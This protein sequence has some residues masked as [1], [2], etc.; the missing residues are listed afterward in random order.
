M[1]VL[2]MVN[3]IQ[4]FISTGIEKLEKIMI[5]FAENPEKIAEMVYGVTDSITDLGLSIIAEELES[6]DETLRNSAKRKREWYIVRRDETSLL[7]SLG[8][9][10]YKKTL[11][12]NKE[13]GKSEYLLD[14]AMNLDKHTRMTEDA[15]AK[16]LEE[17]VESSYRKG[18]LNV[19][20][21]REEVSK[22]T[23]KNKVHALEFPEASKA[24][25][26]KAMP[27]LYID[28]DEDHVALQFMKEKGDLAEERSRRVMPK[29]VYVYEG[30]E[31]TGK[32]NRLMGTKY[33]GG[34]YEGSKAIETLWREVWDYIEDSYDTE[35]LKKVYI[36]GDGASW[37]KTGC[38]YIACSEFVLDEFHLKKYITGA[39]SHLWDSTEDARA[40]IYEALAQEDRRK[41]RKTF[42][43]ILEVTESAGKKKA[44]EDAKS[45]ILN[46]WDGIVRKRENIDVLLGCSAEGHVSHVYA[47]RLSS[48]PLGWSVQGV[49]K[50]ARLRIYHANKGDMLSLIRYQREEKVSGDEEIIF[51]S[52]EMFIEE[53][54]QK[55][56]LGEMAGAKI[57][58][59]PYP[60]VRKMIA[61][62]ERI[63]G[64]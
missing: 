33:F 56:A 59:I 5:D 47:D 53:R 12:K 11:F 50:M 22:Q 41:A 14:R 2:S 43:K 17:A 52:K 58:R 57:Y 32:R 24:K 35:V 40:M 60:Q 1:E 48:R 38:K 55:K 27:Y 64:L 42:D 61:I 37:I 30:I 54:R 20:I 51:T 23:V 45:Y 4:Q 18:G 26:R 62:Q 44:V 10:R 36:N 31:K 3:S 46:H 34:M 63:F 15:E 8:T 16:I 19:S 28:C 6:H 39:T 49:D 7:T 13:T 9:V 21:G 29:I 25:L